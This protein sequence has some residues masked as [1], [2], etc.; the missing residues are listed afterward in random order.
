MRNISKIVSQCMQYTFLCLN[1]TTF[2]YYLQFL[3][4]APYDVRYM[5]VW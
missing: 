4:T 5:Y 3:L 1:L 2:I